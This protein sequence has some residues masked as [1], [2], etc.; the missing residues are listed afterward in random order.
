[1][2]FKEFIKEAEES[3]LLSLESLRELL[4]KNEFEKLS[5]FFSVDE[6]Y[7]GEAYFHFSSAYKKDNTDEKYTKSYCVALVGQNVEGQ[8]KYLFNVITDEI[9]WEVD[10]IYK[11]KHEGRFIH[12]VEKKMK[13]IAWAS[14]KEIGFNN[15]MLWKDQIE[16]DI[17]L[18]PDQQKRYFVIL[19]ECLRKLETIIGNSKLR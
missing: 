2:R 19:S 6:E 7:I 5:N 4:L 9:E 15:G 14:I 12:A 10:D 17:T 8:M 11:D 18:N 1:M 16:K 13:S 3:K